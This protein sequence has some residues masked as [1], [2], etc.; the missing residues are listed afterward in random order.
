MRRSFRFV[1]AA[2]LLVTG[3]A[4]AAGDELAGLE[5][6][7]VMVAFEVVNGRGL[8]LAVALVSIE[9]A[10]GVRIVLDGVDESTLI[11]DDL[12]RMPVRKMLARLAR[13]Y[14]LVYEVRDPKTLV[15]R[16]APD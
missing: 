12:E 3:L 4:G 13:E 2:A 15:V 5:C 1:I 6:E 14:A 10:A 7:D 16:P 9:R 8:P 11:V